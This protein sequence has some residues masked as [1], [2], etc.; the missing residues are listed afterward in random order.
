MPKCVDAMTSRNFEHLNH[1]LSGFNTA[2]DYARKD[3]EM[4]ALESGR[5]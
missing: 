1:T 4:T 3:N 2:G 5:K